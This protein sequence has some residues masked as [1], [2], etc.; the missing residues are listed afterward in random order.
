MD[1]HAAMV[2]VGN[3]RHPLKSTGDLLVISDR[4]RLAEAI[5]AA[6]VETDALVGAV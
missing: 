6:A 5:Y 1:T 2:A 3:R 4:D